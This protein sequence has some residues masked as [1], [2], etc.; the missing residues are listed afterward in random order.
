MSNRN[1]EL[2]LKEIQHILSNEPSLKGC[3]IRASVDDGYVTLTGSVDRLYKKISAG[4][5]ILRLDNVTDFENKI[6][7]RPWQFVKTQEYEPISDFDVAENKL[8]TSGA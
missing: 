5:M 7:I 4:S 3:E 6:S 8:T 1:D 2:L